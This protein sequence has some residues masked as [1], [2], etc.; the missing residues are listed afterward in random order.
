MSL[1]TAPTPSLDVHIRP[2]EPFAHY[3]EDPTD[4]NSYS[5]YVVMLMLFRNRSHRCK[6]FQKPHCGMFI[7]R[8]TAL[9]YLSTWQIRLCACCLL[10][11]APQA[12]SQM[13]AWALIS[14]NTTGRRRK[15]KGAWPSRRRG[16]AAQLVSQSVRGEPCVP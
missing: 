2:P 5:P 12:H 6:R 8:S 4:V 9:F 7:P 3:A 1:L 13:Y 14:Q 11:K 15:E 16:V 10:L